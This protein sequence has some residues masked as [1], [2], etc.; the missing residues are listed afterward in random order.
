[1][2]IIKELRV[3]EH[4]PSLQGEG[5]NVGCA[6][7]FIRLAGCNI[8][9][10]FCD[11]KQSWDIKNAALISVKDLC[12]IVEES[13]I[14]TVV[15]TG[16]EPML[17]DLT[18][19]CSELKAKGVRLFLETTG[20]M[21][22]SGEWDWICL[23]PK[24]GYAVREEYFRKADELKVVVGK[25][26]DFLYAE[27]LSEKISHIAALMLQ[28]EWDR[29]ENLYPLLIAYIQKNNKWKLSVQTHK[30]LEIL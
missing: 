23:S 14:R 5:A 8:R 18:Y 10:D 17:Y 29:R 30:Y 2:A 19:L 21:A 4:F 25:G 3:M 16:G 1:M 11:V 24:K 15:I 20:T 26:A 13:G 27:A 6:A 28:V 12:E 7:Y 22:L 9:C